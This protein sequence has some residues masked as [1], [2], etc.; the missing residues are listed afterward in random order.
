MVRKILLATGILVLVV[1]AG[2]LFLSAF[3]LKMGVCP[4][5]E[6]KSIEEAWEYMDEHYPGIQEWYTDLCERGFVEDA[7]KDMEGF[8]THAWLIRAE[9]PSEKTAIVIHGYTSNPP[10]IIMLARMYR[11]DFGYNV[12]LPHLRYHGESGGSHAQ[13]GW[14]DR[15]D[16][17]EWAEYAHEKFADTL[18]VVHGISMGGATTMMLSGED[19]P[20]YMKGFVD[21]CGYTC[22]WDIFEK[23]GRVDYNMPTTWPTLDLSS[24]MCRHKYGWDFKEASALVQVAK[25]SKP[26]LFIHGENDG[27]VPTEMVY[28]LYDAKTQGYKKLWIAPGSEHAQSYY[29]HSAEY[30]AVVADFLKIIE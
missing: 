15:L 3:M 22:V 8:E 2:I 9:Q 21:D 16:V 17:L 1:A 13:M 27:F 30:T 28:R 7:Q 10:G 14:K 26:M 23:S 6:G 24:I 19:T 12:V 11:E 18:Q 4:D 5:M 29:D 20:E 25:C